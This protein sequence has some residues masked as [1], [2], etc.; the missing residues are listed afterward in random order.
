M[1]TA[2]F[3][4]STVPPTR[5]KVPKPGIVAVFCVVIASLVNFANLHLQRADASELFD[6]AGTG[7]IG[8]TERLQ[9]SVSSK[10]MNVLAEGQSVSI[11]C[12]TTGDF[13]NGSNIWDLLDDGNF[14]SDY[15]VNTRILTQSHH[16]LSSVREEDH[17]FHRSPGLRVLRF[18]RE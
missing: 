9:P 5:I 11:Q 13:V 14:V 2:L 12:Q 7:G 4:A 17:R 8:L 1:P 10:P 18:W 16:P 6:V 15:Y 3:V